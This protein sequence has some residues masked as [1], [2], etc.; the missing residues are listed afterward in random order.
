MAVI[1]GTDHFIQKKTEVQN[2]DATMTFGKKTELD[3][4]STQD[5]IL[6]LIGFTGSKRNELA[7]LLADRLTMT[8]QTPDTLDSMADLEALCAHKGSIIVVPQSA[9]RDD[10]IRSSLREQGKVFYLM[11]ELLHLAQNLGL[12]AEQ[13]REQIGADFIELEPHMLA[14]LHFILH[15]WKEP[16][17]LVENVL[18]PLGLA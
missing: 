7:A 13:G 16:E 11:T 8:V 17:D 18:E 14:S 6:F 12:D 3:T 10:E 2:A 15:G 9:M 5:G 4:F 1:N